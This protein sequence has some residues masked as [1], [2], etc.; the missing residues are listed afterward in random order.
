METNEDLKERVKQLECQLAGCAVAALGY[1]SG[2]LKAKPYSYGWSESYKYVLEL[3]HKYDTLKE[4]AEKDRLELM[5]KQRKL[6]EIESYLEQAEGN[7]DRAMRVE[8][9]LNHLKYNFSL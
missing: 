1:T 9:L 8:K 4:A 2:D 3:R 6:A 5:A 7:N